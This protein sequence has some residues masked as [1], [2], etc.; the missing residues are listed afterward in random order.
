MNLRNRTLLLL[1]V[2]FCTIFIIIAGVSFSVTRSGLDQLESTDMNKALGQVRS[3]LDSESASLLST[4]QDW[5][6][7]DETALFVA[8]ND[9]AYVARNV[10]SGSLETINV[11]L[12]LILDPEGNLVYGRILSPDFQQGDPLSDV[13]LQTVRG[14]SSL[15]HHAK[16]DPGTSGVMLFPKGPM[17]VASTPILLSDRGGPVLGTLVMGRYVEDGPLQRIHAATGYTTVIHWQDAAHDPLSTLPQAPGGAPVLLVPDNETTITGYGLIRDLTGRDLVVGV[18]TSRDIYHAGLAN[19]STYLVL[20]ILWAVITAIIVVVVMDRTVLKR[21]EMLTDWVRSNSERPGDLPAPVLSGNDELVVLERSILASREDLLM[22]ERQLKVFINA[23]PD[24]AALYSREGVILI[25]NTALAA[26]FRK[27]VDE[28]EGTHIQD[29]IAREELEQHLVKAREAVRRKEII[30]YEMESSGKTLLMTH[31][32]ILDAEGEVAQ[33]GLLTLDISER[34]RL[35]NALQK[36]TRKTALLNTVIFNDI[37]NKIFV[38][39]GYQDLLLTEL[40]DP[41]LLEYLEKEAAAVKEVQSSLDFARQYNDMG[42]SPPQWGSVSKVMAFAISHLDSG[43]LVRDFQLEGLEIYADPLLERVFFNLIENVLL[44][45][46]GATV[47]RAGYHPRGENVVIFIEDDGVG[48][49][50]DRKERIFEKGAGTAG[51]VGLFLSR[52]ILSITGITIR[53]TGEAGK[54]AR[55]EITVP[56]G[57]Y[58]IAGP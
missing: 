43:T 46:K 57:S 27:R 10:N 16:E 41:R 26:Y 23:L 48:I 18:T 28:I 22:S 29:H 11:H 25:A 4:A 53:E 37:Q 50:A 7:W 30:Q 55:F 44:H 5:G 13:I 31:Y 35:E 45:A 38:Q 24:P 17:L 32:P 49:P 14:T 36:V 52:E 34:K 42:Q 40:T 33:I 20:L 21:I 56:K 47:I 6:W 19:I 2:I 8:T 58:R 15:V 12:F 9:S 54:G 1:G 39:R 51:A 3:S